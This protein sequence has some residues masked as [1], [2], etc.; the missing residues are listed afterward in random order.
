MARL[1]CLCFGIDLELL[2]MANQ[3]K[4]PCSIPCGIVSFKM[5]RC[6]ERRLVNRWIRHG[7]KGETRLGGLTI[8]L[9]TVNPPLQPHLMAYIIR[10][11]EFRP[12]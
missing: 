11:S 3:L 10:V 8:A 2:L 1:Q 12:E 7:R 4:T 5:A 6:W 9:E